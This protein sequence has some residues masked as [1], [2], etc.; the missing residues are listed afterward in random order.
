MFIIFIFIFFNIFMV[1]LVVMV[2]LVVQFNVFLWFNVNK[3]S[4]SGVFTILSTP[5][6]PV[7]HTVHVKLFI[8]HYISTFQCEI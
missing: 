8:L 4:R 1:I 6:L 2:S 7:C 5:D 3:F